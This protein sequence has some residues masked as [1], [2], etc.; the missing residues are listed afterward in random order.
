M[1]KSFQ[2]CFLFGDLLKLYQ[3]S[4]NRVINLLSFNLDI[5]DF[6]TYFD[7]ISWSFYIDFTA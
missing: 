6:K 5:L 2:I 3:L 4:E 1:F 7:S